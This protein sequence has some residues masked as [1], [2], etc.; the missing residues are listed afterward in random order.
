[1]PRLIRRIGWYVYC[2][3]RNFS[4]RFS[5]ENLYR[6][7]EQEVDKINRYSESI[8]VL[9]VGAGGELGSYAARLEKTYTVSIDVDINRQPTLV[10]DV[11]DLGCFRDETFDVVMMMEVLEHVRTPEAAIREVYRVLKKDGLLL[12]STPFIFEI[13]D[14]PHDFYRFTRF[15][16]EHLLSEFSQI[17]IRARNGYVMSIFVLVMR[18][19]K[20]RYTLDIF[21]G[22]IGMLAALLLYP[23]IFLLN[24]A[25]RSEAATSGY[26]VRC[27]KG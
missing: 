14:A 27:Q 23:I 2:L 11:C 18:L 16:L 12:L 3:V 4:N 10:A 17:E 21:F 19:Y 15:G 5:R 7:L 22:L 1:M 25:I 20:S 13:H 9:N 26:V 24:K 8:C 6:F